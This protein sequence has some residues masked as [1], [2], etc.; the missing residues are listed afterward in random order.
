MAVLA[1]FNQTSNCYEFCDATKSQVSLD[2]NKILLC[3]PMFCISIILL[4][5]PSGVA[6]HRW[7]CYLKPKM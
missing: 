3:L 7:G 1:V 6:F 2:T 5:D 4:N